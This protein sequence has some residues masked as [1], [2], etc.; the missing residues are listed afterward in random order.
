M[1]NNMKSKIMLF[2]P[3]V[4]LTAI[5]FSSCYNDYGLSES[6]YDIVLTLNDSSVDFSTYKTF[7]IPDSVVQLGGTGSSTT[8]NSL[9]LSSFIN[10]LESRGYTRIYPSDTLR[11]D[12]I[13]L[14]SV[15]AS[16]NYVYYYDY[17]AY[18]GW[19]G[20]GGYYPYSGYSYYPY[21]SSYSFTTGT[22]FMNLIDVARTDT[23][24]QK[25]ASV[26]LGAINGVLE[27]TN[28]SDKIINGVN[29]AFTQSPYIRTY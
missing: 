22:M 1:N 25:I 10:Q 27:N 14:V 29:Q 21:Y 24:N 7:I 15:T 16:E 11:A 17:W 2:I 18:W 20:W 9:M 6:D 13:A 26:W 12:L 4:V 3:L 19:Y 28:T 23:V 5:L 8:Y